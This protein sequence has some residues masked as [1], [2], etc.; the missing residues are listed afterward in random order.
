MITDLRTRRLALYALCT[1]MLMI[2]LDATIVNV[3]LPSI[4]E[5]LGFTSAGLAWVV[6]AYLIAFGGLLLLAGRLGDLIGQRRVFLLGL[7]LFTV[8]S[9]ACGAGVSSEL[10][11]STPLTGNVRS[12]WCSWPATTRSTPYLSNSGSNSWRMPRSAPLKWAEDMAT[13]CMQTMIQSM[14]RSRLAARSVR[15][16]QAFCAPWLYPRM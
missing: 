15:S 7:G 3:A 11:G 8:A 16:S 12:E 13:W 6:N 9:V 2:V 4:Q 14:S 5:D 10:P 1:G